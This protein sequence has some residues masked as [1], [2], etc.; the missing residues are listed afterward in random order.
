L[1]WSDGSPSGYRLKE[2]KTDFAARSV[3]FK[4]E[5]NGK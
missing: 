5:I 2:I 1:L 3:L 4:T